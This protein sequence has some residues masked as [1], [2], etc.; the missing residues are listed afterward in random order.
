[1][2]TSLYA[3]LLGADWERLPSQVRRLHAEGQARGHF[4]V[5]RG[6]GP[7]VALL[8][9]LLRLPPAGEQV[10]T[11]LVVRCEGALQCWERAFG[12]HAL[13]TQQHVWPGGLLAER[14][15]PIT[16]VF[17]LRAEGPGMRYEQVGAWMHL[18]PLRLR[19][20][21]VLAPRIEAEVADTSEGMRV[22]VRIA[23]PVV[24]R[25]LS[26]EGRVRPEENP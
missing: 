2:P 25:L 1:M 14:L 13:V 18:G 16:C 15:G 7:L 23:A 9:A 3:G 10:P 4:Q 24:G 8:G 22:S 11:R 12:S 6:P 17:R 5:R 20:P 21:R 19:L 26:Y